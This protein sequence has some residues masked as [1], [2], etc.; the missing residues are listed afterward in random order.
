MAN[1]TK[2]AGDAATSAQPAATAAPP[3]QR[4]Q[5]GSYTVQPDGTAQRVEHTRD[6]DT[7]DTTAKAQPTASE[8]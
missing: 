7:T 2:P 4:L 3:A 1:K 6:A 8:E 5:G